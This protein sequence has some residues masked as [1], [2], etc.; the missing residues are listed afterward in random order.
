MM[1]AP[2]GD[3]PNL[4]ATPEAFLSLD[5]DR[6]VQREIFPLPSSCPEVKHAMSGCGRKIQQ[7]VGRRVARSQMVEECISAL[8][9]LYSGG[10]FSCPEV[11]GRVSAAQIAVLEHISNS[12]Q[13]LG[14]PPALTGTEALSQLRAFDGYGD[15]QVPSAVQ[16]Y[17]PE[18]L[19]LPA[20]GSTPIP[21]AHLL[22]AD[23]CDIVGEFTRSRLLHVDE[24][25]RNLAD[26][27]LRQVYTDPC[28][29]D[30][31]I[32]KVFL[33]RL[34]DAGLVELVG[35]KPRER[36]ECFFVA[37][38]NGKQRMVIDCR[39]A[40]C[41]FG[42]PD[43]VRL[44][45]AEALSRIDLP[46][47]SQL[48]FA[49]ADLK[50]AF[51]HFE[52]PLQLRP[53][54]GTRPVRRRD[55]GGSGDGL[56]Y[57]RLTVLPMG[58][59][60]ALWWCQTIHQR[61]VGSAGATI[62]NCLHDKAVAPATDV[63]HLEYVDNFVVI[64]TNGTAVDALATRGV[65]ALRDKGLVI[66]EEE[67]SSGSI[68]VLGW[69]FDGTVMKPSATRVWRVRLAICRL[70][71]TGRATGKQLEKILGHVTF[72][73]LG[74]REALSIFGD[75]YTF[76]RRHYCGPHRL[77][78][79]VVRELRIFCGI[80]PL[81]WRDLAAP[82]STHVQ[83]VDAS[84]WGLGVASAE[85]N[86]DEVQSLGRYSERWRFDHDP[87][88]KPRADAFGLAVAANSDEVAAVQWATNESNSAKARLPPMEVVGSKTAEQFFEQVGFSTVNK[89]WVVSGRYKWKRLEPIPVLEAR[90][91]LHSVKHC[92][93]SLSNF[94]CKH[95]VLSD[96][97]SAVCALD[98]GRGRSHKMR[99]VTQ[100]VAALCLG[101]NT[102]FHFRWI[103]SEWNPSDGPSRGSKFVSVPHFPECYGSPP[104]DMA[105]CTLNHQE[106]G[107]EKGRQGGQ[108]RQ[109]RSSRSRGDTQRLADEEEGACSAAEASRVTARSFGQRVQPDEVPRCMESFRCVLQ[110]PESSEVQ[111]QQTGWEAQQYGSANVFGWRGPEP[112]PISSGCSSVLHAPLQE[113]EEPR[114]STDQA[115]NARLAQ[116]RPSQVEIA[117]ALAGGLP[118]GESSHGAER[119]GVCCHDDALLRTI[120]ET[121]GIYKTP[122]SGL[123]ACSDVTGKEE[124]AGFLECGSAS[125]RAVNKL[126]NRRVRRNS[127]L[128]PSR[129]TVHSK[130]SAKRFEAETEDTQR[131]H[132]HQELSQSEDM[133]GKDW[134]NGGFGC[135]GSCSPLPTKARRGF[136][137]LC[138]GP[139]H[140]RTGAETRTMEECGFGSE[141]RKG[142]AAVSTDVRSSSFCARTVPRRRG[143]HREHFPMPALNPSRS[144][145]VAVFLE[146][147][148]GCG[149]L[150]KSIA[151]L[152]WYVLMWDITLGPEYDLRSPAKR[153]MLGDWV[154]SGWIRGFHLGTPCESFTRARDI[155][156][157][158]PPLRSDSAPLGLP[159]LSPGDQLKVVLGNLWMRFSVWLLRLGLRFSVPGSME[160]PARSRIWLCAP[161]VM[162]L[163]QLRVFWAE[164]HY[165]A[166]GKPFKKPTGFLTVLVRFDRL[167]AAT[168]YSSKR[169]LCQFSGQAHVQLRG[170]NSD[171]QWLTRLAQPYP[172][173]MRNAIANCFADYEVDRVANAMGKYLGISTG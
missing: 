142:G 105:G 115:V 57:P 35:E 132:F 2:G 164:T 107:I 4:Q 170:Q 84:E 66:H 79:S 123:G 76:I 172:P 11:V 92:L 61:I 111:C 100:Q 83:A 91:S 135:A 29:R 143:K 64:D 146:N 30:P 67:S 103:P 19:S 47:G 104:V 18:A 151:K 5:V 154:R 112:G 25:R 90:A 52:L 127:T 141:V 62:G 113:H 74:R 81:I 140:P 28:L 56:F 118:S 161:V 110:A 72:I 144:L 22:G 116:A 148:S 65:Q 145:T 138:V 155:R 166:W 124:I 53:Y 129:D 43:K 98:R 109:P 108:K 156:P 32:Y 60:H 71:Q 95:L 125:H 12:V 85:F 80:I 158:P 20:E 139:S 93:R 23:G 37:K 7:R 50:D 153:R 168:C 75:T 128:R 51:Y 10:G 9:S 38:K 13:L 44:C 157:G 137:R 149:N 73:S 106:E 122:G 147:F 117:P 8:N 68:K 78:K 40:N 173:R 15:D 54:F 88:N 6:C 169:G 63:F 26:T 16:A 101:S 121:G 167:A 55:F 49:T 133:D 77:W 45:T 42:P 89:D 17:S 70:L 165:C 96:S 97:I 33:K 46:A 21:L 120:P 39:R 119:A 87:C 27:G 162:L 69:E 41:W 171:G 58:W 131:V 36:V 48:H 59:S 86:L 1:G 134:Q 126:Q 152:G 160:N 163:R 34:L 136:H 102:S 31:R 114:P 159:D 99:R 94:G 3:G 82:W 14:S 150:S 130:G 24:A